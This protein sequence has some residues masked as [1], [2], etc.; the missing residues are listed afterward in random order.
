M[1]IY[2]HVTIVLITIIFALIGC[3]LTRPAKNIVEIEQNFN[4]ID[5]S[6]GITEQEAVYIAQNYL[7]E[8]FPEDNPSKMDVDIYKLLDAYEVDGA[9]RIHFDFIFE[10]K[11]P[12]MYPFYWVVKVNKKT[13]KV[14]ESRFGSHK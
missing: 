11:K 6:N 7:L 2:R 4:N 1:K 9:F 5:Y 13:G 14:L 8:N 12:F 10:N 3:S